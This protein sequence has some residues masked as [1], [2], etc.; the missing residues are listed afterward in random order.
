[1][2]LYSHKYKN[3][4]IILWILFVSFI[5][6]IPL[7]IFCVYINLFNLFGELPSSKI[8]ENPESE[9]SSELY[10]ADGILLGK[11]FR[12]NRSSV[13]YHEISPN[14]INALIATED[15]RYK[16]HSGIDLVGLF[17]AFFLSII[18]QKKKGGGSTISQQLAKNLFQTRG[19]KY[20]G[21]LSKIPILRTI[22]IKTKEWIVAVNLERAYTKEE[23]LSM[24]LNTVSFGSNTFG[25][26]S[27]AKTF[28]D[29]EAIE[30]TI[31]QS[32]LLIGLLKAPTKYSPILNPKNS[33]KRRNVILNQMLK[34][35]FISREQ[36]EKYSKFPLKLKYK[37]QDHNTGIAR[38][39]RA[40]VGNYLLKWAKQN[41]YD[42]YGDGLKIYTTIDSKLQKHA[43]DAVK[44]H[45]SELQ[46]KFYEHWGQDNPWI[47]ESGK[48]I[49]NFIEE[50]AKKTSFY[51]QL[52]K[53]YG[54]SQEIIDKIFDYKT[55]SNKEK[56]DILLE[57]DVNQYTNCGIDSTK[58]E[59]ETVKRNSTYIYKIIK[60]INPE[61]GKQF[62]QHQ[63]K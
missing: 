16:K 34:K 1:M 15:K 2:L 50:K 23:I 21:C 25:I 35:S 31:D 4:F 58:T 63:D 42:L 27:A 10:S 54:E 24:Y 7:Y 39:F 37:L 44:E 17:R 26:K 3:S 46:E 13:K 41:G 61:M 19:D 57:I 40:I 20:K 11:Y 47:H 9:L 12:Y 28:F 49:E 55:I 60:K 43:E 48:E 33:L 53:E 32:A 56:I 45:M 22:I 8:L 62:L 5:L 52:K 6:S 59:I 29:L 30:L 14:I 38:Y 36:Y 51:K 18:L